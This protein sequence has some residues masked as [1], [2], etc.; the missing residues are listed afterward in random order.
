VT[1]P[2]TERAQ[3]LA[4]VRLADFVR[5]WSVIRERAL[6]A[7]DRV[8]SSGWL[9]LGREVAAFESELSALVGIE[10][11]IGCAS[12]LDAI[13]IALRATGI[14]IGDRVLTTPLSAFAT[15]LAIVR[16]GADPVFVDVDETGL[17]DLERAESALA[18]DPGIRAVVPVHLFGH[19]QDLVALAALA[20]RRDV[21][22]IEDC[23]Q[24][25]GARSHER[26]VG[27]VGNAAAT[28][29]Y[30]TKNLGALGD[31]GAVLTQDAAVAAVARELRDYGQSS[32]YVHDRLGLNSRLDEL[33]AAVMRDALLPE[34][35]AGTAR[36]VEIAARYCREIE[37][38][39]LTIPPVPIGSESVWHLFPVLVDGDRDTFRAHLEARGIGSAVHYPVLMS[40][41][42]ALREVL[43]TARLDAMPRA[44]RFAEHEVSIPLHPYLSDVDVER[45]V[46]ACNAWRG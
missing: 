42:R 7:V 43:A 2:D 19:A 4:P 8:G 24:A 39:G 5:Q 6:A 40:D 17:L 45:V 18:D 22:V 38:P 15:A 14:G 29:F 32:K 16:A 20:D 13:E 33:H 21:I 31:G 9:I 23:A 30:P 44:H 25:I 35:A 1:A 36:R 26:P 34:L 3:E 41:Q 37:A 28:S 11:A 10:H 46:A 12:G 27:T